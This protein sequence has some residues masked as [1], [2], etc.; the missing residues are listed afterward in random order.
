MRSRSCLRGLAGGGTVI[1]RATPGGLEGS[2]E[3][4]TSRSTSTAAVKVRVGR[5]AD[6]IGAP[7]S[8][9]RPAPTFLA[10]CSE[11]A[12]GP[13]G[14]Y[15]PRFEHDACGIGP[16]ADLSNRTSHATVIKADTPWRSPRSP[17]RLTATG[18]LGLAK[19][20]RLRDATRPSPPA[21]KSEGCAGA[22]RFEAARMAA[23]VGGGA[24]R[25]PPP[26][27]WPNDAVESWP[28]GYCRARRPS[29]VW[30]HRRGRGRGEAA[31]SRRLTSAS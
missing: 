17:H 2:R 21:T 5:G 24:R 11:G 22:S 25:L 4:A 31:R 18:S 19:L 10:N 20:Q 14:L 15:D 8:R 28:G 12:P 6:R 9:L 30:P 26:Y 27:G 13:P 7:V 23:L 3:R 1:D 16:V 29:E